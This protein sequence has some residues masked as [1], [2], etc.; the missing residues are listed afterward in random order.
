MKFLQELSGE[1]IGATLTEAAARGT[2]LTITAR[3]QNRWIVFRSHVLAAQNAGFWMEM[4]P[5]A[6]GVDPRDFLPKNQAGI[7]FMLWDYKR[8]LAPIAVEVGQWRQEDKTQVPAL[9]ARCPPKMYMLE[10]RAYAR[11]NVPTDRQVRATIWPGGRET[12]PVGAPPERPVWTGSVKDVSAGGFQMRMNRAALD[13]FQSG[14]VVGARILFER[15]SQEV[16]ADA[17]LRYGQPD[18]QMAVLGFQ[19]LGLAQT[20]EGRS[21]LDFL[22][23][24][25]NEFQQ[26]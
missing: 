3:H 17:Q 26:A 20:P 21:A 1:E 22:T 14:D 8:F 15:E 9:F 10:R 13:Y 7:S 18:G 6:D 16:L 4:P 2:P 23:A 11:T 24:K 5:P 12:E 19:F 25:V